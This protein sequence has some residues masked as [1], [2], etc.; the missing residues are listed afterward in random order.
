VHS[1]PHDPEAFTQGFLY[2]NG[3]FYESTGLY[4]YSSL[5]RIIPQVGQILNR[6]DFPQQVFAEG[7][8]LFDGKLYMLTWKSERGV[9][10]DPTGL[11]QLG[12]FTYTGEG[13]G[14]THD[15]SS[16]IMSDGTSVLRFIDPKTFAVQRTIEV[17]QDGKA[18]DQLNEL[19]LVKGEIFSN[20][21]KTNTILRIDPKDGRVTG[22]IDLTGIHPPKPD[23]DIDDVLNGIAYDADGD[24]LFV[25]GKRWPRVFE[26]KLVKK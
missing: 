24:H 16:L 10:C 6:V 13:W 19:E 9:V 22:T 14:L 18:I 12:Q 26:I 20:V 3:M 21:W 8:T 5:R 23:G 2:A 11:Q 1:Y 25:T 17:K 7:L 15:A 4:G